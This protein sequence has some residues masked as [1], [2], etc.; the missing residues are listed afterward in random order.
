MRLAKT[1]VQRQCLSRGRLCFQGSVLR[2]ENAIFPISRKRV[3]VGQ[4]GVRLG[5]VRILLNRDSEILDGFLQTVSS[6]LVPEVA[7]LEIGLISFGLHHSRLFQ[8]S[9]FLIVQNSLDLLGNGARD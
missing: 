4:A 9:L 1:V 8:R 2:S 7:T 3:G 5:I 6:A